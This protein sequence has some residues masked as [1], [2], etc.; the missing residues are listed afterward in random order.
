MK[1]QALH[2]QQHIKTGNIRKQRT[3]KLFTQHKTLRKTTVQHICA[4]P[5][6]SWKTATETIHM[7]NFR[8][9]AEKIRKQKVISETATF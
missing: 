1:F 3:K 7:G 6:I 9:P 8:N 5:E 2:Q 4:K